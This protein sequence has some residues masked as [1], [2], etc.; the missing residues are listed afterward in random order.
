MSESISWIDARVCKSCLKEKKILE[1]STYRKQ[2]GELAYRGTCKECKWK[3]E[4]VRTSKNVGTL[5]LFTEDEMPLKRC[6]VCFEWMADREFGSGKLACK[7]CESKS[8][9]LRLATDSLPRAQR[10]IV[11]PRTRDA[12]IEL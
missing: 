12:Q 4:K 7:S 6:N 10:V 3:R 11:A 2:N 1:F 9:P 8:K 5:P